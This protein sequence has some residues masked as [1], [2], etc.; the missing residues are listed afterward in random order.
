[1]TQAHRHTR[2]EETAATLGAVKQ[3]LEHALDMDDKRAKEA[4]AKNEA[5]RRALEQRDFAH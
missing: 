4:R 5:Q 1:M 3:Q 2:G